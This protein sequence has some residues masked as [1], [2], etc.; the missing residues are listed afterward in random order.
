MRESQG[1]D[2]HERR[3]TVQTLR[4]GRQGEVAAR[5]A[6]PVRTEWLTTLILALHL[7]CRRWRQ[8]AWR[9]RLL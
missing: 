1:R 2:F 4:S 5:P 9:G 6:M 3:S 8:C 7:G